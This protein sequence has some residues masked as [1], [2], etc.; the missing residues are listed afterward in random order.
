MSEPSHLFVYGTLRY[1]S[2]HPMALRL[3]TKARH[4]GKGSV[5]GRL[6]DLGAY[7]AAVFD[8]G[9]KCRII[10]DV[11]KILPGSN[12][13]AEMDTYE[14][15]DPQYKRTVLQVKLANG[16]A[17]DAWAYGVDSVPQAHLIYDGDFIAHRN[18]QH[19]R[20]VRP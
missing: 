2:E 7:P 11:F 18:R 19:P 5:P 13:L 3:R 16:G 20:A 10:G 9:E 12:V 8:A 15:T 6:Y 1:E 17:V 14:G 4:I